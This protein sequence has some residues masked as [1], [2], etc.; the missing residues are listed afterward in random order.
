M[1]CEDLEGVEVYVHRVGV[2]GEVDEPPDLGRAQGREEG[3]R[4]LE[5]RSDRSPA[6]LVLATVVLLDEDDHG[7]VGV[8][9]LGELTKGQHRWLTFHLGT[10]FDEGDGTHRTVAKVAAA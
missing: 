3:R 1:P 7:S 5:A 8:G 6:R 4:V 10:E 9:V 2:T